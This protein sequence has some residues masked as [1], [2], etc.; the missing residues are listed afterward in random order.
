MAKTNTIGSTLR[1]GCPVQLNRQRMSPLGDQL[2]RS[3]GGGSVRLTQ[4]RARSLSS[5]SPC[6]S[7]G[8][9]PSPVFRRSLFVR[10]NPQHALGKLLG[11]EMATRINRLTAQEAYGRPSPNVGILFECHG[12]GAFWV[13]LYRSAGAGRVSLRQQLARFAQPSRE[14]EQA[15]HAREGAPESETSFPRW[16]RLT[17][18]VETKPDA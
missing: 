12:H 9:A 2:T 13:F 15:R 3:A 16:S 4:I 5:A 17:N 18:T 1:K 14:P 7:L 8:L 10:Y 6:K 11:I